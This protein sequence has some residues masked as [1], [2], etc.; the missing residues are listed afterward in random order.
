M[1]VRAASRI[2][3]TRPLCCGIAM[4]SRLEKLLPPTGLPEQ[5]EPPNQLI[6]FYWHYARQAKGLFAGLFAA[7]FVVAL[8]DSLIPAFIGRL[9]TLLT[10]SDPAT[11]FATYWPHL[12]G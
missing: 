9:V 3:G 8:L 1:K 11:L 4:F 12:I 6:A 2:A 5:P 10:T 7:G